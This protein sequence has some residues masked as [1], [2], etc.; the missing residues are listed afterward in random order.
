M[1]LPQLREQVE[2]RMLANGFSDYEDLAK[3]VSGQGY[4]ISDDSPWALWQ[5]PQ[6]GVRRNLHRDLRDSLRLSADS[7]A[8]FGIF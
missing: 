1:L 5:V 4:D 2:Q 7:R 3:W 6:P 8:S